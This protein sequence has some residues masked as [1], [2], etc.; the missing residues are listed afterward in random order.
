ML[1]CQV[2]IVGLG[3]TGMMLANEMQKHH[4]DYLVID[5]R[6]A[7]SNIPRAVNL[8]PAS[9]ALLEF[10]LGLNILEKTI[11]TD[12]IKVY[13]N[14]K[15]VS[16]VSYLYQKFPYRKF[17]YLPQPILEK[18]LHKQLRFKKSKILEETELTEIKKL[19]KGGYV[20]NL[21]SK[22]A[23]LINI[24]C[25]YLIGCD[26]NNS[27]VRQWA[28]ISS[29]EEDYKSGFFLYDI[30]VAEKPSVDD[31]N[32]YIF[33]QGYIIIVP[34]APQKY[35]IILSSSELVNYENSN[36]ESVD[37]LYS[38]IKK[39]CKIEVKIKRIVW[40][41]NSG[42]KHRIANSFYEQD[43]FLVGDAFHVFSPVGGLNM[44][45]GLQDAV[46]LGWKLAYTIKGYADR[47]IL[48][49]YVD[50]RKIA[51]QA[52]KEKTQ[53]LTLVM[54]KAKTYEPARRYIGSFPNRIF[55]KQKLPKM[56]S[57]YDGYCELT[58]YQGVIPFKVG[59]HI[60]E[61]ISEKF[62][63]SSICRGLDKQKFN[64]LAN[65][66]LVVNQKCRIYLNSFQTRKVNLNNCFLL[67]RPDGYIQKI[68]SISNF[69][70]LSNYLINYLGDY[71]HA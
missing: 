26:G 49:T 50:E 23:G 20:V 15:L 27:F 64:L 8:T 38:F 51:V 13:W 36:Y 42:F 71:Q 54:I 12:A 5:K 63:Y 31:S 41:T 52:I 17:C 34:I 68:D 44:N 60:S 16:R 4:I 21:R 67:L 33:E 61:F 6:K 59:H 53:H 65:E 14:N 45:T 57:G 66:V 18:I 2:L 10:S 7:I 55:F 25:Q 43:H 35:R 22:T 56:L 19:E 24:R 3:P 62:I 11:Q 9:L 30:E 37:F 39:Y 46:N 29:E 48:K 1:E 40:F 47:Q 32:Y 58:E 28:K 70:A 69:S